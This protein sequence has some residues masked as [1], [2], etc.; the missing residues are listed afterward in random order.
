VRVRRLRTYANERLNTRPD[1]RVYRIAAESAR[2]WRW[3]VS[4]PPQIHGEP[5]LADDRSSR[6]RNRY[7]NESITAV[8]PSKPRFSRGIVVIIIIIIVIVVALLHSERSCDSLRRRCG[9]TFNSS[10]KPRI[11]AP[12]VSLNSG[13]EFARFTPAMYQ[14][15]R[16][17]IPRGI[18]TMI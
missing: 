7:R 4:P 13:I 3:S 2:G 12:R 6:A 18:S 5:N 9:R 10:S 15:Q 14:R 17:H 8:L 1:A 11:R 16:T